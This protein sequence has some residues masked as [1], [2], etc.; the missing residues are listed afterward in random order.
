MRALNERGWEKFAIFSWY[1]VARARLWR[2]LVSTSKTLYIFSC[3][4]SGTLWQLIWF[5]WAFFET[6][7]IWMRSTD[8][9]YGSLAYDSAPL[10]CIPLL[11][12]SA[13][14]FVVVKCIVCLW[15][16]GV[17][18]GRLC[19]SH[20]LDSSSRSCSHG[21]WTIFTSHLCRLLN[22]ELWIWAVVVIC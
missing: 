20:Q 6:V 19:F 8:E 21:H 4:S 11:I 14:L 1:G 18:M 2:P 10:L 16:A 9:D 7:A 3:W 17:I 15:C 13:F 22:G 5:Y 12:S